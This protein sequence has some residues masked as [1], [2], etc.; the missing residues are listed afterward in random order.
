MIGWRAYGLG[1]ALS[2][3]V[4]AGGITAGAARGQPAAPEPA[5]A[6]APEQ[7]RPA[8][9]AH[10]AEETI[11]P[12]A[13]EPT[14]ESA[15]PTAP[16]ADT[17]TTVPT[18]TPSLQPT[19]TPSRQATATPTATRRPSATAT[20][21]WYQAALGDKTARGAGLVALGCAIAAVFIWFGVRLATARER[22]ARR[23]AR[24]TL[25]TACLA[26]LRRLDGVLR[27]IVGAGPLTPLPP[28]DHPVLEAA[29]ADLTIFRPALAARLAQFDGALRA[30]AHEIVE[31]RDLA[32][33]RGSRP[34][35]L[36]E[37]VKNRAAAACRA[38]PE[39]AKALEKDGARSLPPGHEAAGAHESLQLP[40]PPFGAGDGDDWTL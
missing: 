33:A 17:A 24:R 4:L 40:P 10:P 8:D 30:L 20:A 27:R 23:R 31:A 38:V 36:A 6:A 16:P 18:A 3:A 22:L 39:L 13:A 1:A 34:G 35:E 21:V 9:A 26:E 14:A 15:P 29:L 7:G 5:T 12:A 32:P 11:A 37:A 2:A 19:A 28:L 25:A